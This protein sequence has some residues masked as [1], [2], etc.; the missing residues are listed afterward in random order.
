LRVEKCR[1]GPEAAR[2]S[3][4]TALSTVMQNSKRREWQLPDFVIAAMSGRINTL[5]D[6]HDGV[7]EITNDTTTLLNLAE[8]SLANRESCLKYTYAEKSTE[9]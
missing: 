7:A 5:P 9:R 1:T 8:A 4:P 2:L 6:Y 3:D